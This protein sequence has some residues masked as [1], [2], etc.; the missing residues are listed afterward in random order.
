MVLFCPR[1]SPMLELDPKEPTYLLGFLI[2]ELLIPFLTASKGR[3]SKV[4]GIYKL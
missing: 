2:I 4:P 3:L 1:C